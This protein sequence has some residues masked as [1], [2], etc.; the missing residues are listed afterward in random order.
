MVVIFEYRDLS[1]MVT[2]YILLECRTREGFCAPKRK[3]Y[4]DLSDG[5]ISVNRV[6]ES[7]M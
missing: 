4:D 3:I 6:L 2:V 5:L 7:I 1:H